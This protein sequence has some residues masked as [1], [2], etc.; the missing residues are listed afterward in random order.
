[1]KNLLPL[2]LVAAALLALMRVDGGPLDAGELIVGVLA[3]GLAV[4]P[5]VERGSTSGTGAEEAGKRSGF[6][7]RN[8]VPADLPSPICARCSAR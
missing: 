4:W 8:P 6:P 7:D 2:F 5:L 3:A 1:M